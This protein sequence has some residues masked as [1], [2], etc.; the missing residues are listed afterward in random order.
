MGDKKSYVGR[1]IIA[2]VAVLLLFIFA[3]A[4]YFVWPFISAENVPAVGVDRPI[5]DTGNDNFVDTRFYSIRGPCTGTVLDADTGKPVAGAV[6]KA[7]AVSANPF[8]QNKRVQKFARTDKDGKYVVPKIIMRIQ[9][10]FP[11]TP[12]D[13]FLTV[14]KAGYMAYAI[15]VHMPST[16]Y[17]EAKLKC[18]DHTIHLKKWDDEKYTMRD[19]IS[20]VGIVGCSIGVYS[21]GK[22]L[23]QFCA[24]AREEMILACMHWSK[25]HPMTRERCEYLTDRDLGLLKEK[26]EVK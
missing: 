12:P 20:N 21:G 2:A 25:K 11:W 13:Y 9:G 1:V 22:K 16:Y 7:D 18:V 24:E 4:F 23:K 6:V 8:D 14:Y 10:F 26:G 3:S 15:G 5:V 17:P 19:H